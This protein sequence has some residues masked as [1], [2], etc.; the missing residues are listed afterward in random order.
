MRYHQG[1]TQRIV[2]DTNVLIAALLGPRGASRQVVRA[3][4]Q[5]RYHVMMSTSLALES[6]EVANREEIIAQSGLS[7]ERLETLLDALFH[8]CHWHC[9]YYTWRPNLPDEGDNHVLELAVAS[10]V[11]L[12]VTHNQADFH[13]AELRFPWLRIVT[14]DVLLK[15]YP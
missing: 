2:L 1:M 4:L 11:P 9:V 15:E 5:G 8:V 12:L 7:R 3:S 13:R 10:G 6:E 14:P